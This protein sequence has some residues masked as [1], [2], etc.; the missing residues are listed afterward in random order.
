MF[1]KRSSE[2]EIIDTGD[3]T[4]AEYERFLRE[5]RFINRWLGD[6]AALKQTLLGELAQQNLQE[7]SILDVGAGSGEL[8]R[9]A[10]EFARKTNIKVRLFGLELN[11]RS[12]AA[13]LEESK[14]YHNIFSIRG[15]AFKLPFADDAFDYAFCSLFAHHFRDDK[16][17]EILGEMRRVAR[18]KIFVIDLHRGQ[19]AYRGYRIFS[20]IFRLG[21][22]TKNDGALSILRAFVP[23]E[24][25]RLG[26]QA[27]L[28]NV[29]VTKHQPARLVLHGETKI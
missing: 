19:N 23:E 25:T 4:P 18:R 11:R 8:L 26:E 28:K 13:N 17:I 9:V 29:F 3:Y 14:N 16:I 12:A 22:L 21:R 27:K 24:L 15:D 2:L 5:I 10:A 20:F 6:V 1:E 7:F